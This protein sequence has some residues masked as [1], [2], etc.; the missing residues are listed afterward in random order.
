MQKLLF[1]R[2]GAYI[3]LEMQL[4]AWELTFSI[5]TRTYSCRWMLKSSEEFVT[6]AIMNALLWTSDTDHLNNNG[7][8]I[9]MLS[10]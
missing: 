8:S 4:M 5:A 2:V 3:T 10:I 6:F 1:I 7:S 9:E